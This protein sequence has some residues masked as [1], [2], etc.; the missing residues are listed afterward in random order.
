[1]EIPSGA[2]LPSVSTNPLPENPKRLLHGKV[3][4][5]THE[6]WF[7]LSLETRPRTL[8]RV[9]QKHTMGILETRCRTCWYCGNPQR[10]WETPKN[11]LRRPPGIHYEE[12]RWG[13]LLKHAA[14]IPK[15][16]YEEFQNKRENVKLHPRRQKINI[17][18]PPS[19]LDGSTGTLQTYCE[20]EVCGKQ[21]EV[22]GKLMSDRNYIK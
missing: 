8:L 5:G 4:A 16:R 1:M 21:R 3:V 13:N 19:P 11:T 6:I 9:I 17:F 20:R 15:T 12:K 10:C 7:Y 18:D 22:R 2:L 14:E